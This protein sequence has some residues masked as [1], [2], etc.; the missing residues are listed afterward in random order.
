MSKAIK[1]IFG[2]EVDLAGEELKQF[3][4]GFLRAVESQSRDVVDYWEKQFDDWVWQGDEDPF[5]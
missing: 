3:M 1:E 4:I 5:I 2:A